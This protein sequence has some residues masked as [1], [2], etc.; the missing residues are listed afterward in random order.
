M[1]IENNPHLL[2]IAFATL[3][4][5]LFAYMFWPFFTPLLLAAL[6]AFALDGLVTRLTNRFKKRNHVALL[7]LVTLAFFV[8]IPFVFISLKT[9]SSIKE[10]SALGLQNTSFYHLTE[11][12]LTSISE[13]VNLMARSLDLDMSQLPQLGSLLSQSSQF[14][15]SFVTDLVSQIPQRTLAIFVFLGGLYYFL[16]QSQQIKN[17]FLQLNFFSSN[18]LKQIIKIVKRSSYLTFVAS[19]AVGTLQALIIATFGYFCG[20][21]EFVI[22]FVLTFIFSLI[23]VV[24]SAPIAIFLALLGFVEGHTGVT[25]AMIIASIISGSI[26]NVVKPLIV[27]SSSED[28]HPLVSLIALIG[29]ILVYGIPG[30]LLGPILTQLAFKI[31]PILFPIKN[32]EEIIP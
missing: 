23:P 2:R 32:A 18:E 22:L 20:F 7:V 3:V 24:G 27:N 13:K 10:Y 25:I 6:F 8:A 29:A 15:A 14:I 12:L 1:K 26:D 9:I 28:L 4:I 17:F 11:Q 30:I 5:S 19:A 16:T 21:N 31:I